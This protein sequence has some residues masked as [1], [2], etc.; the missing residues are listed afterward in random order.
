MEYNFVASH[1]LR[2]WNEVEFQTKILLRRGI[3]A[4]AQTKL[5]FFLDYFSALSQEKLM[6][7]PSP[8]KA[9]EVL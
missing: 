6:S 2:G 4:D 8:V 7:N 9:V 3:N 1:L 5:I